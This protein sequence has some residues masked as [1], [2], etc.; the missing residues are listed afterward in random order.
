V[1]SVVAD[2]GFWHLSQFATDY[3]KLFDKRPSESLRE[4]LVIQ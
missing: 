4:A 1:Q 2:W 3:R